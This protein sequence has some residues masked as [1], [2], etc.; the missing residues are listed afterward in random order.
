L[1]FVP[2]GG[3]SRLNVSLVFNRAR[4]NCNLENVGLPLSFVIMILNRADPRRW[5]K[6]A[7]TTTKHKTSG[8]IPLN[9]S[10]MS[11]DYKR[12]QFRNSGLLLRRDADKTLR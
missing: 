3:Q 9:V 10:G 5:Q 8:A 7:A 12:F 4:E 2:V 11:E 1:I 6:L